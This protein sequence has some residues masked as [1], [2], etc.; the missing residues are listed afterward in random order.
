MAGYMG[1]PVGYQSVYPQ[2]YNGTM[3]QPATPNI[4]Q[5]QQLMTPPTIHAEIVQV[6]SKDEATNFPVGAGQSQMMMMRDDSAI[7]IKTVYANGQA[8]LLEYIKSL[9]KAE[10][11]PDYVTRQELEERLAEI[12][13]PKTV[14]KKE[15]ATNEP[16]I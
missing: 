7:F 13:K 14:K 4:A 16:D 5:T 12:T 2:Q 11:L 6:S 1:F 15:V 10:P 9:P 8:S 3:Y